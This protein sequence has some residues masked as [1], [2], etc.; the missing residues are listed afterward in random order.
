MRAARLQEGIREKSTIG[1]LGLED[2]YRGEET[3]GDRTKENGGR[4]EGRK[5]LAGSS[6]VQA[7][8]LSCNKG[9]CKAQSLSAQCQELG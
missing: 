3:V 7:F 8:T 9:A 1:H 4:G 6:G 5:L 2:L